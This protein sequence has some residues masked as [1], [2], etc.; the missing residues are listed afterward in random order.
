MGILNVTPD[1]LADGGSHNSV[2]AAVEYGLWLQSEGA[3]IVDVGGESSRPGALPVSV[4]EE[5]RRVVPVIRTLARAWNGPISVDTCKAV[6]AREALAAG[7]CIVND[8]TALG[9][10]PEM[11]AVVRESRA[12]AVLMHMQGTPENMQ[13]DPQ[14]ADV[15][16]EVHDWLA[17]RVREVTGA[18]IPRQRLAIDP[19][20][21]FGKTLEHNLALLGGLERFGD[22]GPP[23]LV[24][25]SR[26]GF[27]GRITGA[28][29]EDRLAGSLA[30]LV[31]CIWRGAAILRVLD[32]RASRDAMRMAS[33]LA[34]LP[35][36]SSIPSI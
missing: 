11:L 19:G 21:G 22:I 6:V 25:L 34:G 5:C 10:D 36:A 28:P 7:A 33:A 12:G 2:E 8:I 3:D 16:A 17:R 18:G 23:L 26:K 31:W 15:V 32:V 35:G 1:S 14:Y 27:I 30:G 9:G 24:G 13:A 29:V 4:E 20:I